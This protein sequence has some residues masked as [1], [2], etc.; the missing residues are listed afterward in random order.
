MNKVATMPR[1]PKTD[2]E[3][4]QQCFKDI[5]MLVTNLILKNKNDLNHDVY[6][7]AY[8]FKEYP[9]SYDYVRN[10]SRPNAEYIIERLDCYIEMFTD[11]PS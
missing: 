7:T 1:K 8:N 3:L 2:V 6:N 11:K 4:A 5:K 9:N 10:V